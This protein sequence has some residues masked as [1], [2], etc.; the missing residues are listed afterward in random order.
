MVDVAP[1][2]RSVS[3]LGL[4]GAHPSEIN[5]GGLV[6]SLDVIELSSP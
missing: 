2:S 5:T 1:M 3:R 6:N 4:G